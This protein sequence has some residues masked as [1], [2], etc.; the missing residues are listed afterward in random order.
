MKSD[1][2]QEKITEM[3]KDF[4]GVLDARP[5]SEIVAVLRVKQMKH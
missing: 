3:G 1:A 4:R 5:L 2:L